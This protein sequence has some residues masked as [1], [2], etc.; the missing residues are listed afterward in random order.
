MTIP[1]STSSRPGPGARAR[2][3]LAGSGTL[4]VGVLNL[5]HDIDRHVVT[6]DGSLLFHPPPDSPERI[7][8]VAPMLPSPQ[9]TATVVDVAAVAMPDRIRGTLTIAGSLALANPSRP[10][11]AHDHPREL[12]PSNADDPLLCLS[13]QKLWL[14]WRCESGG[15]EASARDAVVPL[16]DYR[17]A[18]PDPLATRESTWL[19][20]LQ[21]HHGPALRLL[22]SRADHDLA[23]P[24]SVWVLGLDRHG[25]VLRIGADRSQRDVR[26]A[27]DRPVGCPCGMAPALRRLL[28][29][30]A[31][32]P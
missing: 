25:V 15:D 22:A 14:Q 2:S 21:H 19:T 32:H 1:A 31:V 4:R 29:A 6:E 28:G 5:A 12:E 17:T 16:E 24:D 13:P 7:F 3:I 27:F 8:A 11:C 10:S 9:I 18:T 30:A 20:H 26:I 23:P